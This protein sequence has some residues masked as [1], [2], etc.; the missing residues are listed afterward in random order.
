MEATQASISAT[1]ASRGGATPTPSENSQK[2]GTVASSSNTVVIDEKFSAIDFLKEFSRFPEQEYDLEFADKLFR[3][4]VVSQDFTSLQDQE[5]L[6]VL[7]GLQTFIERVICSKQRMLSL[8]DACFKLIMSYKDFNGK[9]FFTDKTMQNIFTG[10]V[11]YLTSLSSERLCDLFDEPYLRPHIIVPAISDL[12]KRQ[13]P[14]KDLRF[15]TNPNY[16]FRVNKKKIDKC[17]SEILRYLEKNFALIEKYMERHKDGDLLFQ[18]QVITLL[19]RLLTYHPEVVAKWVVHFCPRFVKNLGQDIDYNILIARSVTKLIHVS[20]SKPELLKLIS[21]GCEDL[22]KLII[23]KFTWKSKYTFVSYDDKPSHE[24]ELNPEL[25]C[26]FIT[27]AYSCCSLPA[28]GPEYLSL[29]NTRLEKLNS[30]A[31]IKMLADNDSCLIDFLLRNLGFVVTKMYH[32]SSTGRL[33][34]TH[35]DEAHR[36]F[37]ATT[38]WSV[39]LII[40]YLVGD[41]TTF[42]EYFIKFLKFH[43]A[44]CNS[45]ERHSKSCCFAAHFDELLSKLTKLS[46]KSLIPYNADPL[47][48]RLNR[49]L[50]VC[51]WKDDTTLDETLWST[52]SVPIGTESSVRPNSE[53]FK[54]GYDDSRSEVKPLG[55]KADSKGS[56]RNNRAREHSSNKLSAETDDD[57]VVDSSGAGGSSDTRL[58]STSH[59]KTVTPSLPTKSGTEHPITSSSSYQSSSSYND[60]TQ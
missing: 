34:P 56:H 46:D 27:C 30:E 51:T 44:N 52:S 35:P 10:F 42:L 59:L 25:F 23:R 2:S 41:E 37:L 1:K 12:V 32:P 60:M 7:S 21:E 5:F 36:L 16:K 13:K 57:I 50:L 28:L 45:V 15:F 43:E 49:V 24:I 17:V 40:D 39:Q 11:M 14:G 33:L 38:G 8:E 31:L 48:N 20:K 4:L 29:M 22:F 55:D 26:V 3:R 47:L 58:S 53:D 18:M 6:F 54:K 19:K 9:T